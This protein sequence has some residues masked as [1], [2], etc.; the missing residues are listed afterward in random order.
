[1]QGIKA[2]FKAKSL[3]TGV[4]IRRIIRHKISKFFPKVKVLDNV[5]NVVSN[6]NAGV[7]TELL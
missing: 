2:I 4:V 6:V 3:Y 7:S 1:V 5:S